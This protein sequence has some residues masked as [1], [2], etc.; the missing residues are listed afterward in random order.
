[1]D[2]NGRLVI[3]CP[4]LFRP[5]LSDRY[6]QLKD[7]PYDWLVENGLVEQGSKSLQ[8]VCACRIELACSLIVWGG[9][10]ELEKIWMQLVD[11]VFILD[12][13]LETERIQSYK[14]P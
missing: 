4:K 6:T 12:D 1:M 8:G 7:Y 13:F 14:G 5:L 2:E 9:S 3:Y 11:F 10:L